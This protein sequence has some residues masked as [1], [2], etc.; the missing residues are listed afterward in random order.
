MQVFLIDKLLK[1][2]YSEAKELLSKIP[3]FVII[4]NLL[5]LQ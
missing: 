4:S 5:S 1:M 3:I 2:N